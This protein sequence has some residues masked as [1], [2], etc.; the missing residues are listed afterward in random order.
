MSPTE[1]AKLPGLADEVPAIL[2]CLDCQ[3][4]L[5]ANSHGLVCSGSRRQYSKLYGVSCFVCE[6]NHVN[7]F[8]FQRG[9]YTKKQ[10]VAQCAE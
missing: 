1:I 8:G 9:I 3:G 6:E 7:S 5:S 10:E 4:G 2:R